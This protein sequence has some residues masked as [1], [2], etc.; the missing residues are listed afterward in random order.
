MG[1]YKLLAEIPSAPPQP[2]PY[3]SYGII[4]NIA[5]DE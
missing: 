3:E 1:D 5:P 4:M 2:L